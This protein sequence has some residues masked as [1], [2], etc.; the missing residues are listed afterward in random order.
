[1]AGMAGHNSSM[2]ICID[3]V[4]TKCVCACLPVCALRESGVGNC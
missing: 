2:P 4:L 3:I 1:M